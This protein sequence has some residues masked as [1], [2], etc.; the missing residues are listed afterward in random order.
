MAGA[1]EKERASRPF[2]RSSLRL[3]APAA[4]VL[5]AA[6]LLYA[7]WF[8]WPCVLRFVC[9][10]PCP[11][12]GITRATRLA[13]GGHFEE[14]TRMHP[15]WFVVVPA[16]A[17]LFAIELAVYARTG[18]FGGSA[19]FTRKRAVRAALLAVVGAVV[20]VWIARF[21]GFLGGPAPI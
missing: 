13:M 17:A 8:S 10:V 12:C 9:G 16:A 19:S 20:I 18:R 1:V 3:V 11:T 15:L 5:L 21:F 4:L 2:P 14:A 7:P 6:V